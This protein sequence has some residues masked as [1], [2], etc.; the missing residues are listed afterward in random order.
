MNLEDKFGAA[1]TSAVGGDL[2]KADELAIVA[3]DHDALAINGED[4]DVEQGDGDDGDGVH[5]VDVV[6]GV[7]VEVG[8]CLVRVLSR[9]WIFALV[10]SKLEVPVVCNRCGGELSFDRS[11]YNWTRQ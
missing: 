3:L 10:C 5:G 2:G 6:V 1:D 11:R 8:V 9:D 7:G 4:E